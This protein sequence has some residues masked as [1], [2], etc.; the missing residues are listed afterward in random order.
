M[1]F[2]GTLLLPSCT[3]RN[4]DSDDA[5][6]IDFCV[7]KS[8]NIDSVASVL[9]R[10]KRQVRVAMH[11]ADDD[12]LLDVIS[13]LPKAS[14]PMNYQ[15]LEVIASNSDGYASEGLSDILVREFEGDPVKFID[16]LGANRESPLE[17]Y[18]ADGLS[19][20]CNMGELSPLDLKG[21]LQ[22]ALT[23]DHQRKTLDEIFEKVDPRKFD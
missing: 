6:T 8:K 3:V 21:R 14:S 20:K 23:D 1:I 9:I 17:T 22:S 15:A 10:E 4:S 13:E 18:L 12:C 5:V 2:V 16:Y 7:L 19:M 11:K